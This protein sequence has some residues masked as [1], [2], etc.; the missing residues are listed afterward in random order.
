MVAVI[1]VLVPEGGGREGRTSWMVSRI[2]CENRDA[3]SLRE[4]GLVIPATKGDSGDALAIDPY[5]AYA[6]RFYW[7]TVPWCPP[8]LV[9]WAYP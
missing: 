9:G 2:I 4:R 1:L 5:S 8:A 3:R 7:E 6:R